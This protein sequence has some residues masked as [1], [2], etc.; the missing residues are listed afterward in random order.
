MY[1]SPNY[2]TSLD[3]AEAFVAGQRHGTLVVAPPDGWPQV[4]ILPFLKSGDCIELHCVRADPTYR[5][6][7]QIDRATFV[8]ADYL[9][10]TPHDWVDE[11]NAARATLHFRAVAYECVATVSEDPIDVADVLARLITQYEPAA[12]HE[13]IGDGPF[14]GDRL[15]RLAVVRLNV[16]CTHAK[17][18][19]GPYG[20]REL[21][22]HV[23]R[24]LR[25]RGEPLDP[26]AA[27]VIEA[28]LADLPPN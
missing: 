15:R 22:E 19:L 10:F 2:P 14:Y 9:A 18:K 8:V 24:R 7:E 3:A 4:T 21:K 20:S 12:E 5:A 23:V 13:A 17:F 27:A 11:R 28:Y 1:D 25:A 16:V 6:L 26:R